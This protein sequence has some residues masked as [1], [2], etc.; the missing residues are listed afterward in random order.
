MSGVSGFIRRADSANLDRYTIVASPERYSYC[1]GIDKG[2]RQAA[3]PHLR[4][5]SVFRALKELNV[6]NLGEEIREEVHQPET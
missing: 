1:Q 2:C 4:P 5:V 3:Q 6:A